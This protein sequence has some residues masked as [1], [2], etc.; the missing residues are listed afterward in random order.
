MDDAGPQGPPQGFRL[1]AEGLGRGPGV[2]VLKKRETVSGVGWLL[3]GFPILSPWRS[4]TWS[5]SGLALLKGPCTFRKGESLDRSGNQGAEKL[6]PASSPRR[7]L[8][9]WPEA[10]R[11]ALEANPRCLLLWPLLCLVSHSQGGPE[12]HTPLLVLFL[13]MEPL[14]PNSVATPGKV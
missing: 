5:C 10:G 2:S 8:T 6:P 1:R 14:L 3:Q 11:W 4:R 9:A 13:P 7:A 12:P